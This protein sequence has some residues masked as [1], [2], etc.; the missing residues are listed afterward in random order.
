ME[1]QKDFFYEIQNNLHSL[2]GVT[3]NFVKT[4]INELNDSTF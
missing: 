2:Q 3:L 4:Q 1:G